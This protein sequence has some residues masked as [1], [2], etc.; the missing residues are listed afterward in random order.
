MTSAWASFHIAAV[1][2]EVWSMVGFEI[3]R[4]AGD[5]TTKHKL[6][7]RQTPL[8]GAFLTGLLTHVGWG[9]AAAAL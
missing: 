3:P 1:A 9:D 2:G 4:S 5:M 7:V 6:T 8:L